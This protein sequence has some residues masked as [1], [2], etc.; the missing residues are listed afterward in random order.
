[1]FRNFVLFALLLKI[2]VTLVT[3][4]AM[5]QD[6]SR[7]ELPTPEGCREQFEALLPSIVQFSY[8]GFGNGQLHFGCGVIVSSE[9]HIVVSGPDTS[10]DQN[11]ITWRNRH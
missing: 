3:T 4:G 10:V 1:M 5:A 9:G 11:Q 2:V 6:A 7:T 8:D